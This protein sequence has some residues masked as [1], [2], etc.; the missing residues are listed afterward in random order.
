MRHMLTFDRS[1]LEATPKVRLYMGQSLFGFGFRRRRKHFSRPG[2]RVQDVGILH[3]RRPFI[4]I[5]S[6]TVLLW[7]LASQGLQSYPAL[8]DLLP[9][10]GDRPESDNNTKS[11][12]R[13]FQA[14]FCV[15]R[16]SDVP[17]FALAS[18]STGSWTMWLTFLLAGLGYGLLHLSAWH[19]PFQSNV[20]AVLWRIS[21]IT[22]TASGFVPMLLLVAIM[23]AQH[24]MDVSKLF[25]L[26]RVLDLCLFLLFVVAGAVT[27]CILVPGCGSL[28]LFS[29]VYIMLS[30]F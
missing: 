28:Y 5:N 16:I 9:G 12:H 20:E 7:R 14:E 15:D 27:F 29:R 11:M 24:L 10:K 23:T 3:F 17:N 21:V 4:D 8:L 2:P 30:A 18:S 26:H 19:S 22:I 13:H 25:T 1:E 6:P